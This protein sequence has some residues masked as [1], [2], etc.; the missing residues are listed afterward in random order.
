ME[1]DLVVDRPALRHFVRRCCDRWGADTRSRLSLAL[2][3]RRWLR[4]PGQ[5]ALP[6]LCTRA[7]VRFAA[8]ALTGPL[9]HPHRRAGGAFDRC[10]QA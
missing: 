7:P 8:T 5:A 4:R 9:R 2:A 3:L 10:R 6:A 1:L